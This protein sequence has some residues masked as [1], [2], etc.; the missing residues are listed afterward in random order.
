MFENPLL[1]AGNPY[2]GKN[3]RL[4]RSFRARKQLRD[5]KG[6]WIFMG[7]HLGLKIKLSDGTNVR[8]YGKNLGASDAK[9]GF[10]QVYISN[11]GNPE[12]PDGFYYAKGDKGRIY[13][14]ILSP[15]QLKEQ[16][17]DISSVSDNDPEL[18][19]L[20]DLVPMEA[21]EGWN[22]ISDTKYGTSDGDFTIEKG[23]DGKWELTQDEIPVGKHDSIDDAF[24]QAADLDAMELTSEEDKK[25]IADLNDQADKLNDQFSKTQNP[26]ALARIEKKLE[27]IDG[28][29]KDIVRNKPAD[30]TPEAGKDGGDQTPPTETPVAELPGEPLID[31][32]GNEV[33]AGWVEQKVN[34]QTQ[35]VS[36]DGLFTVK[37]TSQFS[38]GKMVKRYSVTEN[39]TGYNYINNFLTW[40]KVNEHTDMRRGVIEESKTK[41]PLKTTPEIVSEI[42]ADIKNITDNESAQDKAKA[43]VAPFDNNG[44]IAKAIDNG[45]TSGEVNDML[46]QNPDWVAYSNEAQADYFIDFPTPIDKANQALYGARREAISGLPKEKQQEVVAELGPKDLSDWK[47]VGGQKGSNKGGLYEGPNGEQAYVKFQDE[48]HANNE[49]LAS[50]LYKLAGIDTA[51]VNKG[52]INGEAVTYSPIVEGKQGFND[53]LDDPQFMEKLQDGFAADAWLA[54]WDVAGLNNDNVVVTPDN[55]PVRIDQGGALQFRAQGQPKGDAFGDKADEV[56]SMIDLGTNPQAAKV[57]QDMTPEQKKAS[58][59]LIGAGATDDKISEAVKSVYGDTPEADALTQKLI[60]RRQDVIARLTGVEAAPEATPA[61]SKQ[62]IANVPLGEDINTWEDDLAKAMEELS[63]PEATTTASEM[64]A[65]DVT[66]VFVWEDWAFNQPAGTVA[67]STGDDGTEFKY[68]KLE[69]AGWQLTKP[70]DPE[71]DFSATSNFIANVGSQGKLRPESIGDIN[72]EDVPVPSN[73]DVVDGITVDHLE[74][75]GGSTLTQGETGDELGGVF[76]NNIGTYDA[77]YMFYS[78]S[79]AA[80]ASFNTKEEAEAWLGD[81]IATKLNLE[82]NPFTKKPVGEGATEVTV[83]TKGMLGDASP[84]QL[85]ALNNYKISKAASPEDIAALETLLKKDKIIKGEAG[86]MIGKFKALPNVENAELTKKEDGTADVPVVDDPQVNPQTPQDVLDASIIMDQIKKDH[87]GFVELSESDVQLVERKY[88][89]KYGHEFS[90]EVIVR[91]TSKERF[92]AYVRETNLKTGEVR[93]MKAT[94]EVHSYKALANKMAT[95]KQHIANDENPRLWMQ[96]S[97]KQIDV[98]PQG[99]DVANFNDSFNAEFSYPK[100]EDENKNKVIEAVKK[101]V[102]SDKASKDVVEIL[103][104]SLDVPQEFV[105]EIYDAVI[106]HQFKK[107]SGVDIM[108]SEDDQKNPYV[109]FDGVTE[110]KIGDYVDWTD[111]NIGSSTYGQVF[112]GIVQNRLSYHES[113]KYGYTDAVLVIFPEYNAIHGTPP[114]KQRVRTSPA[115]QVVSKDAAPSEPFKQKAKEKADQDKIVKLTSDLPKGTEASITPKPAMPKKERPQD[116][117]TKVDTEGNSY[118]SNDKG[119]NIV[120][121]TNEQELAETVVDSGNLSLTAKQLQ[122]GDLISVTPSSIN[123]PVFGVVGSVNTADG[124]TTVNY[125]YVNGPGVPQMDKLHMKE[126]QADTIKMS[127][128]R[129]QAAK[130]DPQVEDLGTAE[131]G[132]ESDAATNKQKWK[133]KQLS[134]TKELSTSQKLMVEKVQTNPNATKGDYSAVIGE[135]INLPAAKNPDTTPTTTSDAVSVAD[136][137]ISAVENGGSADEVPTPEVKD[138]VAAAVTSET[139]VPKSAESYGGAIV[140]PKQMSN[141]IYTKTKTA[142]FANVKKTYVKDLQVGDMIPWGTGAGKR[143]YQVLDIEEGA[144]QWGGNLVTFRIVSDNPTYNGKIDTKTWSP[145]SSINNVKVPRDVPAM[146]DYVVLVEDGTLDNGSPI[147]QDANPNIK[148]A[149]GFQQV[150][151]NGVDMFSSEFISAFDIPTEIA[152]GVSLQSVA[153]YSNSPEY[154]FKSAAADQMGKIGIGGNQE[155]LPGSVVRSLDKG[156]SGIVTGFNKD[157]GLV[158]VSWVSGAKAGYDETLDMKSVRG[159]KS[160]LTPDKAKEYGVEIDS[161]P[162]DAIKSQIDAKLE[163]YKV[164]YADKII[165]EQQIAEYNA[166][167][168]KNTVSG[169]GSERIQITED[170]G[171]DFK[172]YDNVNS[173]TEALDVV[174]SG[175]GQVFGRQVLVDSDEIEDNKVRISQIIDAD[176]KKRTRLQFVATDWSTNG[177][178]GL[179]AVAA[180][181][182]GATKSD[183]IKYPTFKSVYGTNGIVESNGKTIPNQAGT[184]N[185]GIDKYK[186]GTTYNVPLRSPSGDVI[187]YYLL[188]RAN[189]STQPVDFKIK[190]TQSSD[191]ALS[192]HNKVDVYLD[193]NASAQDIEY[194]LSQIGI[195]AARPATKADVQQMAENKI[196]DLFG[197]KKLGSKNYSGELRAKVLSDFEETYGVS[198]SDVE[199]VQDG[200]DVYLVLPEE[201][202]AKVAAKEGV[203]SF[204]HSWTYDPN[205]MGTT[206]EEKAQFIFNFL[207]DTKIRPTTLRWG[208]GI[209]TTGASSNTDGFG[210]GANYVFVRPGTGGS[211]DMSMKFNAAGMLRRLDYYANTGDGWGVKKPLDPSYKLSNTGEVM[212]KDGISWADLGQISISNPE[213]RA[214]VLELLLS[215]G[216]DT[217]GGKP[218]GEVIK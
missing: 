80:Q 45:A 30:A 11:S 155:A 181:A 196:I 27:T 2:A 189:K 87:P 188:H 212:F 178:S 166:M 171:W 162:Y 69:G 193:E 128:I 107:S 146:K 64:P 130:I 115:L 34:G 16:G 116:V 38:K 92:F 31:K 33:P 168:D 67:Y 108:P 61:I 169:P 58:A 25:K 42:N 176:G 85:E 154:L 68:T 62:E 89:N 133:V 96:K 211:Y 184:S 201:F 147:L 195:S 39:S 79:D 4:E 55:K 198:V 121:P 94:P 103:A 148:P 60:T 110:V 156:S 202:G 77:Q 141:I 127:V 175:K 124:I 144:G 32:H 114:S 81:K 20:V 145:N 149:E 207:T 139:D 29:I 161:A 173:L 206:N 49:I 93:V 135:L 165:K 120:I 111:N 187:G 192:Y 113:K 208:N 53:K 15:E 7:G 10:A 159:T 90:Y 57:F 1:A 43:A 35:Y 209:N 56:D 23:E 160:F 51:E 182:E 66:D 197:N 125:S 75:N 191:K 76:P 8:V 63:K 118:I 26:D 40:D 19:D 105:D 12:I 199:Y 205:I 112:R 214:R 134:M 179:T 174:Q 5:S 48:A 14:A 180:N 74:D 104:N 99:V 54:N 83:H 210:H 37:P 9:E 158:K 123:E 71:W 177:D 151:G 200:N 122:P 137:A 216:N 88:I 106:K 101:L 3:S 203:T 36:E 91:R 41:K 28:G 50:K 167:V 84:A 152:P 59:M 194:A 150:S 109:S 186:N 97:K 157:S 140:Q 100:T 117:V 138:A 213:I 78:P 102:A 136:K 21:P 47:Q 82:A 164:Q 142:P 172:T 143:Y 13:K 86:A 18:Q 46:A 218:A 132:W 72:P 170:L 70:N 73:V 24:V 217:I 95:V 204:S 22:K 98:V 185:L 17:I 190:T 44:D 126:S 119:E 163:E 215:S 129:P 52:T 131:P 6:R 153:G 183:G 65:S